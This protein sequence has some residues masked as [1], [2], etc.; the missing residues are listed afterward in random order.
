M[1]RPTMLAKAV[2]MA[3]TPVTPSTTAVAP[4]VPNTPRVLWNDTP[5][6]CRVFMMPVTF[7]F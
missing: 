5:L 4:R 2:A 3:R 7:S 1:N 6:S